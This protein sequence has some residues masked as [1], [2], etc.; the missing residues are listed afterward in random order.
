MKTNHPYLKTDTRKKFK[1]GKMKSM[2]S[3]HAFQ[4]WRKKWHKY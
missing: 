4:L 1:T 2:I 3:N